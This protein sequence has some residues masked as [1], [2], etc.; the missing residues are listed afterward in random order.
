MAGADGL[1]G[2]TAGPLDVQRLV[3][4]LGTPDA[5]A[6]V[7]FLGVS[8]RSSADAGHAGRDVTSLWYEAYE[9]MAVKQLAAVGAL[10]RERFDVLGVACWHRVGEVPVGEASVAVVVVAGHR[11]PAFEACRFVIDEVKRSVPVW[12]LERF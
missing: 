5:G 9:E 6:V 3:A 10:A 8:R 2:V 1:F 7:T 12:K 4:A 11:G